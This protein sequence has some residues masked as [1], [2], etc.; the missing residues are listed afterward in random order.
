MP[1]EASAAHVIFETAQKT[2]HSG[3]FCVEESAGARVRQAG[4]IVFCGQWE[5]GSRNGD[6]PVHGW[7]W[8]QVSGRTQDGTACEGER[9]DRR[10]REGVREGVVGGRGG[11]GG[12][13]LRNKEEEEVRG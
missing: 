4:G 3:I 2:K 1:P 11:R 9:V 10:V 6:G 12:R 5:M 8:G 7:G 13:G